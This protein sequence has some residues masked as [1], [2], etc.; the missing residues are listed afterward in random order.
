MATP[1]IDPLEWRRLRPTD[2]AAATAL[3]HR[4]LDADGGLRDVAV[5]RFAAACAATGDGCDSLGAFGPDGL[6]AC[7]TVRPLAT[8]V[9]C[10]GQVA[11]AFRGRGLGREL[12]AW[13]LRA[14]RSSGGHCATVTTESLTDAA[15]RLYRRFGL[16][17]TFAEDVMRR[18]LDVALP[19]APTPA[20][21]TLVDWSQAAPE[22]F[23]RTYEA[24]FRDR[25][26][27][28]GWSAE[29]WTA[30]AAGDDDFL[31]ELSL[32]ARADGE[33]LGF[34][35]C[36]RGWVVQMGV[37]P[38]ARRRGLARLLLTEALTRFQ[39][40]GTTEVWLDVNV[41]N[42]HAAALYADFGFH[43]VG[44]RARYSAP[45]PE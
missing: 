34:I 42:S 8:S 6:R 13:S 4:C 44:R 14:A 2:I 11:P 21:I 27:Y 10:R 17:Q 1:P 36:A 3:T 7:A 18:P 30:W 24:S 39:A 38:E 29:H 40:L 33:A 23:F 5:A 41:N 19:H 35:L 16:V 37:R 28:P 32:V 43:P 45:P 25:P 15:D 26:G 31:R 9:E 20:G 22:E 12:L